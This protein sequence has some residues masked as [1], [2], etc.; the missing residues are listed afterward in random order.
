MA[1]RMWGAGGEYGAHGKRKQRV[2]GWVNKKASAGDEWRRENR[3]RRKL[4]ERP[5]KTR[6]IRSQ[7]AWME[8]AYAARVGGAAWVQG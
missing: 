6:T 5:R 7:R 2:K 8:L 1:R 3:L 4:A